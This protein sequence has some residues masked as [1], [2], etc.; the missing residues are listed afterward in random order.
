[1]QDTHQVPDAREQRTAKLLRAILSLPILLRL[2]PPLLLLFPNP[3]HNT[4][5][6]AVVNMDTR[7]MGHHVSTT[8]GYPLSNRSEDVWADNSTVSHQQGASYDPYNQQT[9]S[10]TPPI[11]VPSRSPPVQQANPYTDGYHSG[12]NQYLANPHDPFQNLYTQGTG[13]GLQRAYTLGGSG[14]GD[15]AVPDNHGGPGHI[16][17]PYVDTYANQSPVTTSPTQLY[18]GG[19]QS[20]HIPVQGSTQLSQQP[21]GEG[22]HYDDRPPTYDEHDPRP[23]GVWSSKS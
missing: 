13:Q 8:P 20:S 15:N 4:L 17:N 10:N 2:S 9:S 23:A 7:T 5:Q 18:A 6:L 22:V 19:Y 3:V 16:P 21:V 12:G 11:P 1:M 14:Y